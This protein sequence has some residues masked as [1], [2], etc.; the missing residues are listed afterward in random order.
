L[1]ISVMSVNGFDV[2]GQLV[3]HRLEHVHGDEPDPGLDQP[4]GHQA[5]LPEPGPAVPVADL[6][7]LLLQGERLPG[8]GR[9]HQLV[10]QLDV[11]VHLLGRLR[12]L[13]RRGGPVDGV[14]QLLPAVGAGGGQIVRREQVGHLEVRG[15]RVG[16]EDERVV[17]LA[18]VAGRVAV[19]QVPAGAAD[20][21]WQQDVGRQLAPAALQVAEGTADVRM[22]DPA[23][24]EPTR[25]H[26]LV[27]GVVNRRSRVVDRA[28]QRELVG[29]LGH[30][31]EDLGYL[32]PASFGLDRV[33]RPAD[34]GRGLRLRV[35]G[36]QLARPAD[37]E[38]HDA[39][40]V[41]VPAA[42]RRLGRG[43]AGQD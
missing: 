16:V 9:R 39:I 21:L 10:G 7:R 38:Q 22:L 23:G 41:P 5:A 37:Q 40:D 4:A 33:E 26:H 34:L 36:V 43:V 27:A 17:R 14:P 28:D 24:E 25:L 42:F 6:A 3:E 12:V 8:L 30:T 20:R 2:P 13:E 1:A 35:P 32:D 29:V 19:R 31:G 11:V 18:E 15:G